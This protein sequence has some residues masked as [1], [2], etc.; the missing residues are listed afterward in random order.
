MSRQRTLRA[1][2]VAGRRVGVVV[3]RRRPTVIEECH[4]CLWP[5]SRSIGP[6]QQQPIVWNSR[7]ARGGSMVSDDGSR[8]TDQGADLGLAG[9]HEPR[10]HFCRGCGRSLALGFRGQFHEECLRADKRSR[11]RE[12]RQREQERFKAWLQKQLCPKCGVRYGEAG[13]DRSAGILCETSQSIQER[14]PPK[15]LR[16]KYRAM[17]GALRERGPAKRKSGYRT[18]G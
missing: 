14:D 5:P 18:S 13:S 7:N 9:G 4:I 16:D 17:A 12:Q 10:L 6:L 11:T 15:E 1:K 2:N 3:V 8:Q